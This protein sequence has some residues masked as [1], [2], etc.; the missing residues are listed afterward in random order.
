MGDPRQ[1]HAGMTSVSLWAGGPINRTFIIF[2]SFLRLLAQLSWE[3]PAKSMRGSPMTTVQE[4]EENSKKNN[5]LLLA[6]P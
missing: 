3:I 4:N 5:V 6:T 2:W 1:K